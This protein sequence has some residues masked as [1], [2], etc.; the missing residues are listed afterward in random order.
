MTNKNIELKTFQGKIICKKIKTENFPPVLTSIDS[1]EITRIF[2]FTCIT[3]DEVGI[4]SECETILVY[5]P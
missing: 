5:L 3:K 4:Y 1:S 2:T